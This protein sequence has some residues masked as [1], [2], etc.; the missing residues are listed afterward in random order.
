[1]W[2]T[3]QDG[4]RLHVVGISLGGAVAQELALGHPARVRSLAL[5][6]TFAAQPPRARALLEAWRALY[7][8]AISDPRLRKAWELQAYAWLFTDRFW[9]SE[10]NV[11]AALRFA[12]TQPPQTAQGFVGQVDA[13]LSHDSR[14]RLAGIDVPTLVIHGA[15]DQLSVKENGE[16]LARLI[17]GAELLILPEVGHA[18]NLEGQRAVNGALRALWKRVP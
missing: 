17:R 3:A 10:A 12:S 16:E 18:V 7:P 14:D 13:A 6:S 5:L 11:R 15:L 2:V 1:M 8:V 9:R 4:A